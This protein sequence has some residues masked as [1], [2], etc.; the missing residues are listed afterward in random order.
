MVSCRAVRL[1]RLGTIFDEAGQFGSAPLA[2]RGRVV[3]QFEV[4]PARPIEPQLPQPRRQPLRIGW[5][6]SAGTRVHDH[7]R[8]E[9]I[10]HDARRIVDVH[11]RRRH[12]VDRALRE[13]WYRGRLAVD[14]RLAR[15]SGLPGQL[16]I[17]TPPVIR[18]RP[19]IAPQPVDQPTCPLHRHAHHERH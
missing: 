8:M 10:A 6:R 14:Q 4:R 2:Q 11:Q 9:V 15:G 12:K 13:G 17:L 16:G 18:V 7:Q 19:T 1:G 3:A 5:R